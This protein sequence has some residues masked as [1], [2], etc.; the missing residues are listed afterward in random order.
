MRLSCLYLSK[1]MI[2]V[3]RQKISHVHWSRGP[4]TLQVEEGCQQIFK[5][6]RTS[7][8]N[9]FFASNV[10]S[11]DKPCPPFGQMTNCALICFHPGINPS[12]IGLLH[13]LVLIYYKEG[14]KN[15][16]ICVWCQEY[17][18]CDVTS[19]LSCLSSLSRLVSFR[20]SSSIT[21]REK[22]NTQLTVNTRIVR[23]IFGVSYY[24]TNHFS[25]PKPHRLTQCTP[26]SPKSLEF[27][28][29][30]IKGRESLS[31]N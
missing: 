26:T 31:V 10:S 3:S 18:M 27:L 4:S 8:N 1:P 21:I 14:T 22:A 9:N 28:T 29:Y 11:N 30:S 13:Q 2:C 23:L 6:S 12:Q 25:N 20:M 7:K 5:I 16:Y 17:M 24:G 15:K 19:C